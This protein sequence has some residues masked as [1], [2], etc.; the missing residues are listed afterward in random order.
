MRIGDLWRWLRFLRRRD[1]VM[2]DLEE[3]MTLH[4]ELR[5]EA[6]RRDG[7]SPAEADR[8]ARRRFGNRLA[9]RDESRE[10]WGVGWLDRLSQDLRYASR[11]LRRHRSSTAAAVLTLAL[12]IG[13]NTSM[14]TLLDA[15]L[16]RPAP[17]S[18]PDR[19]VWVMTRSPEGRLQPLAYP[20]YAVYRDSAR[21]FAG[22]VGY[23]TAP[24]AIGGESAELVRGQLATG[25][26]FDV[27][28]VRAALGRTFRSDEDV[29]SH[30]SPVVVLSDALWR[31]RY[32]GNPAIVG[33]TMTLN[34]QDVSIVGIAPPGFS[35]VE[36]TEEPPSFWIP[37]QTLPVLR[38]QHSA[39]F[40]DPAERWLQVVA[41][42]APGVSLDQARTDVALISRRLEAARGADNT[43]AGALLF[44]LVGGLDPAN[45]REAAEVFSL[46]AV[47][48]GLVLLVA[49]ANVAN[50][51]L[52]RAID[53]RKELALRRAIGATRP[54]LVRQLL[55]ESLV[56]ALV[57]GA[58]GVAVSYALTGA[59]VH[60]GHV[61]AALSSTLRVDVR[62]LVATSVLAMLTSVLFGLA[63]A[64]FGSKPELAP[65]LKDEGSGMAGRRGPRLRN[66]FVVGQVTVSLVLLVVAGLFL[67]SMAKALRVEPG[68]DAGRVATLS[69]DLGLLGYGADARTGFTRQL[70]DAANA[71]PGIESAALADV[72]P[73]SG[74]M[75]GT[76]IA[77]ADATSDEGV[78]VHFSNVTSDYFRTLGIPLA[79]GRDFTAQES[80]SSAP[81]AIVNET[82]AR[83]LWPHD[84]PIGRRV[85][86]GGE[87]G[88]IREVLAVARDGKYDNLG[89]SPR[90]FVYLPQGP[91]P[92]TSLSLIVRSRSNPAAAIAPLRQIVQALDPNLP[93]S[94][95]WTLDQAIRETLDKQRAASA[96]VGVFGLLT[97]ALAS[98][99]I[100]GVM[101]H[102][103]TL[104]TRE[105]G[106]RMSLGAPAPVVRAMFVREG[107]RL[108]VIGVAL[109]LA[110]SVLLALALASAFYGLAPADMLAFIGGTTVLGA[111]AALAS[112]LPARRAAR[113]DPLVALRSL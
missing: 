48:P 62:V 93:V 29:R 24:F 103:V 63:P 112:Y 25:N 16:F 84:D 110:I 57:G 36:L 77:P 56:L 35:G 17:A 76:T 44:P 71:V 31:R 54:R 89:E 83:R 64:L 70:L 19:L 91:S 43:A 51:L 8:A 15:T 28:G 65:T 32:A 101:A 11:Q 67:Q 4:V 5:A 66:A 37:L 85:R 58:V 90:A 75:F 55:T 88:P 79:R 78:R 80:V 38:P 94:R 111:V 61:P 46:L 27:L 109:G 50:L 86:V 106:I 87:D 18:D 6:N 42:L 13:A 74:Y 9:T 72:L 96:L 41:R 49:C 34:G 21:A 113:V 92:V 40:T 14:F 26:Y 99:G 108:A 12:G 105:I 20:D 3:E 10:M 68:L 39:M 30:P 81:V 53:R 97:L 1:R 7:L 73:L 100:Y 102:A 47:V 59:I 98:L 95:A 52:A 107:V 33:T 23:S 82:L 2:R 22:V 60:A 104:R 45:R 69:F